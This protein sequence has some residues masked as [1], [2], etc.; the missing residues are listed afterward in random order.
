MNIRFRDP[1]VGEKDVGH[2][3]VVVLTRMDDGMCVASFGERSCHRCQ[4]D[5]LWPCANDAQYFH[6]PISSQGHAGLRPPN[7][8]SAET[9]R[10]LP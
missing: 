8:R 9:R 7:A 1:H 2:L 6:E 4:L 5:E 3:R 10:T